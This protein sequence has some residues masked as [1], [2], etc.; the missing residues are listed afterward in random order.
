MNISPT[1]DHNLMLFLNNDLGTT[2]DSIMWIASSKLATVPLALYTLYV[3]YRKYGVRNMLF[4]LVV[5]A[6]MILFADQVSQFFKLNL[7]R[8]RPSHEPL[9]EGML[10]SVNGYFGGKYG[11]V[12][13]HAANSCALLAFCSYFV[14][15][16]WFS[17]L[18]VIVTLTICYSRI[19][20][21]VHY[22]LDILWGLIL[23]AITAFGGVKLYSYLLC[24]R[25]F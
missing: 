17:T 20:L 6:L 16:K 13:A 9:L 12:S 1:L 11:T 14:S 10:H 21:G 4:S 2:V 19:Y 7:S 8:L 5:I 3:L 23:G 18:S 15:R 25:G 24:K 22:P